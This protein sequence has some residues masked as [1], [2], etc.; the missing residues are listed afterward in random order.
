MESWENKICLDSVPTTPGSA[1]RLK[2][3]HATLV[4]QVIARWRPPCHTRLR[5]GGDVGPW[6]MRQA[7]LHL[8]FL[9][10]G[11]ANG[12][13][14]HTWQLY[15]FNTK[16]KVS[17]WQSLSSDVE[18]KIW[19]FLENYPVSMLSVTQNLP[20]E[21]FHLSLQ[22]INC[23]NRFFRVYKSNFKHRRN[24]MHVFQDTQRTDY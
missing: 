11:W 17:E 13:D 15:I 6:R 21:V 18:I 3:G 14:K 5:T 4:V 24:K 10:E 1:C 12:V 2:S 8:K 22:G 16:N 7:E 9:E 23:A 19:I 20:F